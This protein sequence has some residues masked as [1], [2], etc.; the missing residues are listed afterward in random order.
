MTLGHSSWTDALPEF[1]LGVIAASLWFLWQ[2]DSCYFSCRDHGPDILFAP[3][4]T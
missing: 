4:Y 1:G 3:P 2:S